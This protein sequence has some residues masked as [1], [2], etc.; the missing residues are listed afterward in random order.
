MQIKK[1]ERLKRETEV[2]A[3]TGLYNRRYFR[4]HIKLLLQR[5]GRGGPNAVLM[6]MDLDK[7]KCVNDLY[8][9]LA[10]DKLLV[11]IADILKKNIRTTDMVARAGGDEFIVLL[12]NSNLKH[13]KIG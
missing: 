8:G 3:L 4:K 6:F 5:I 9:H 13:A 10:G 7:F 1:F 11:K 12:Y 2:D